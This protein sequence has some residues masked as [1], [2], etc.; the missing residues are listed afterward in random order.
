MGVLAISDEDFLKMS[1]PEAVQPEGT[2]Q[3]ET[4]APAVDPAPVVDPEVVDPTPEADPAP[5]VDP[6]PEAATVDP[7]VVSGEQPDPAATAPEDAAAAAQAAKGNEGSESSESAA[8]GSKAP[9]EAETPTDY[10]GFY[11]QVMAP[12]HANGK[13]IE[14]KT[15]DEAIKLMQMGAN[16]TRKM[17]AIAPHRKTLMMLENSGMLDDGLLSFAIDLVK[18]KNPEAIKK[19]I[20]EANI[21]PMDIDM[22][23][24]PAY[25]EGN[26][27]VSDS[28]AVFVTALE[29]LRSNAGGTETLNTINQW[30]QASKEVLWKNPE[31]MQVIHEQRASGIY[32][33]IAAEVERQRTLGII[34]SE[35]PFLH[36]YKKAGD[37]LAAAGAFAPSAKAPEQVAPVHK[38]PVAT[39][40]QTPKPVVKSGAN[41][42]A[43]ATTRSTSKTAKQLVNPLAL[44]DDEFLASMASRL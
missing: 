12:L 41:V 13:K 7:Q 31:I 24:A 32:E 3:E 28:E 36:A 23:T 33:K 19:L 10:E 11:K 18:N 17:Q 29:D 5:V 14:L 25:Q 35:A 27:R 37:E 2:S 16:Y 21:D 15:P 8:P 22:A 44:S 42:S 34:P 20:K 1:G 30:D 26:H 4:T 6:A 40:V 38:V 39:T 43:A 9:A